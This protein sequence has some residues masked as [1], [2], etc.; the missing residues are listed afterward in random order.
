M[1][2]LSMFMSCMAH[3]FC[4][5]QIKKLSQ[6]PLHMQVPLYIIQKNKTIGWKMRPITVTKDRT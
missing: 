6:N 4:M 5:G 1:S 2:I 3:P